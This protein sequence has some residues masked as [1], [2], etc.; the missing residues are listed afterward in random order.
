[1]VRDY[2][3]LTTRKL[4]VRIYAQW[5]QDDDWTVHLPPGAKVKS[6]PSA[7]EGLEPLRLLQ[8]ESESNGAA[9]HAEDDGDARE[10]A[11]HGERVP[12]VPRVVRGGRPRARPARHGD[13][14]NEQAV[15]A[16]G[17]DGSRRAVGVGLRRGGA[18]SSGVAAVD[19]R[20][21]G[22]T[23]AARRTARSSAAGRSRRCSRRA[24]ARARRGRARAHT[25]R[26]GGARR[27]CGRASRARSA[28]RCTAIPRSRAGR[29]RGAP[30][31]GRARAA[32]HRRRSS[33]WF[34]VRHLLAC[35]ARSPDLYARHRGTSRALL[36]HP[37]HTRL[38]RGGRARGLARR[39][40]LRQRRAARATRTTTMW[41]RRMGCARGVRLAG[42]FGHGG[43]PDR[44]AVVSGRE[45]GAVARSRGRRTRCAAAC[46]TCSR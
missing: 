36:A 23:H 6:A 37:G 35:A 11:H 21:V 41:S 34:A 8:V 33:A 17:R 22:R 46:R 15:V 38:A 16:L 31:R 1:M 12:G 19:R 32:N 9:L 27:A 44:A 24:G 10:D 18:A 29:L 13:A 5:T 14:R 25:P 26:R 20:P 4:D 7:G 3:P 45:A 30:S 40:G 42:P 39:R 43:A 28:T 2:A